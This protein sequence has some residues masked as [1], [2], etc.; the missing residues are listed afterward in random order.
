MQNIINLETRIDARFK[1]VLSFAMRIFIVRVVCV[2]G[3]VYPVLC[4]VWWSAA[5]IKQ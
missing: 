2:A 5:L 4:A 1:F 3:S